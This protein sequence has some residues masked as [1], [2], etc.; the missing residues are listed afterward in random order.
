MDGGPGRRRRRG[1]A[2]FQTLNLSTGSSG[3]RLLA[4][5]SAV[6]RAGA[7]RLDF[8]GLVWRGLLFFSLVG[9]LGLAHL[10]ALAATKA[11]SDPRDHILERAWLEDSTNRLG[12]D[13]VSAMTWTPYSGALR[14]G[15][16]ASTTWLRLK[17][18]APDLRSQRNP[19]RARQ[20]VLRMMPGHLDEIALFDPRFPGESPQLAGDAQD[21]RLG[22][23][24]SFNQNL[25]IAA[26]AEPIEVLLR[27]RTTGNHGL[28]VEA[29]TWD[30]IEEIDAEQQ[31]IFGAV[32]MFLTS[33]L[34]WAV[35]AWWDSRERLLSVFIVQQVVSII[36]TLSLLG[37]FRVY[38]SDLLSASAINHLHSAV[39]PLTATTVLWFH[40]NFMREFDPPAIGVRF[41]KWI[42]WAT[43][44]ML[45]VMLAG[46]MRLALQITMVITLLTPLLLLLVACFTAKPSAD[47]TP[48]LTRGQ[49]IGIYTAM[50]LILWNATLPAFGWQPTQVLTMYGAVAY[51]VVSASILF[52][53][54][55]RRAK[56]M[57]ASYRQNQ[58]Q[59]AL[60]KQQMERDQAN[61]RE[62][63]QFMTMLTHELTNALATAQLAIGSLDPRLP[64][65]GRGYRAIESMRDIIR[66]CALSGEI[67]SASP[68]P[69]PAEINLNEILR[70][71][72]A[73]PTAEDNV[74]LTVA[75]V[76]P[77][78]L[79]DRQLVTIILGNLLDNALKY[80]SEGTPVEVSA[81]PF[82]RGGRAGVQVRVT[83]AI[84]ER[85]FPDPEKLFKKYWRGSG[86]TR[87]PGSG[88]GLYLSSL[89]A[90]RLGAQLNYQPENSSVS[91]V[92]WLPA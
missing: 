8:A 14:R 60:A 27:L 44:L 38:L 73:R 70:D 31:L 47:T 67:E 84:G 63:E 54:L 36:F 3:L 34:A 37:F 9:L 71:L 15:Y 11:W 6:S 20:L 78:C 28:H 76:L 77:P 69:E 59:L 87:H 13:Q 86:A 2:V 39:F 24:R 56:H 12:P 64:M 62:Q 46:Y 18:A 74:V 40:L 29:L 1:V 66:R 83:N 68:L 53:A 90:E 41:L 10:P 72:C 85:A 61:R 58:I 22:Q 17:I 21:W 32:I 50:L 82:V 81:S 49:L 48:R 75:R 51:G 57:E 35:M 88:L 43:P 80:R 89:I 30:D 5:R 42:M 4:P 92:L 23:Y 19:D 45:V 26:P 33:I 91:F 25:V 65:R 7:R 52:F 79:T 55:R 16:T